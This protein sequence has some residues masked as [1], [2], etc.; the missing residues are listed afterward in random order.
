VSDAKGVIDDLSGLQR[1]AIVLALAERDV[2]G[3]EIHIVCCNP[4]VALCGENLGGDFADDA[5]A[6]TCTA[7]VVEEER[8]A[9]CGAPLCFL[10]CLGRIAWDRY[11]PPAVVRWVYRVR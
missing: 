9:P 3:E 11:G 2:G 5:E 6:T 1:D 7:C 10:R 8:E 4:R